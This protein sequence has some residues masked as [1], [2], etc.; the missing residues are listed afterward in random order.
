VLVALCALFE[1]VAP[2][3]MSELAARLGL[4]AVPTLDESR[5]VS[6]AGQTVSKGN[7]LFPR[8]DPT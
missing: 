1:P 6:L 4:S 8:M 7:P 2:Q 3:K 5:A